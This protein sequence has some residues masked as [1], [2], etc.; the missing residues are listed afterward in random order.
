MAENILTKIQEDIAARLAAAEYFSDIPV[1][2][3]RQG[4]IAQRVARALGP[5]TARG[6]KTGVCV[7]VDQ[8]IADAESV[9]VS[10]PLLNCKIT[11]QVIENVTINNGDSGTKKAALTVAVAVLNVLHHYSAAGLGAILVPDQRAIVPAKDPLGLAYDVQFTM[12]VSDPQILVKVATPTVTPSTG[13]APQTVTLACAT[14]GATI[15]YTVNGN[16]PY[17]GQVGASVY[18]APIAV[19]AAATLRVAASKTGYI[20][21]NTARAV[22]T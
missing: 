8:L 1:V 10:A 20:T 15:L 13:A 16:P 2:M 4:D 9:N 18:T 11:C 21:S 12:R 6:G 14:S 3:E 17:T 7:I 22:Y 5:V 19:S